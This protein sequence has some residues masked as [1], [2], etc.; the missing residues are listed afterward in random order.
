MMAIPRIAVVLA[1][2]MLFLTACARPSKPAEEAEPPQPIGDPHKISEYLRIVPLDPP[3]DSP[4]PIWATA[5]TMAYNPD[6]EG[7]KEGL[8]KPDESNWYWQFQKSGIFWYKA[9]LWTG[10]DWPIADPVVM[11]LK[12]GSTTCTM[13]SNTEIQSVV[14]D[15]QGVPVER[16]EAKW[17]EDIAED[18]TLAT[19][20]L[21][22]ASGGLWITERMQLTQEGQWEQGTLDVLAHTDMPARFWNGHLGATAEFQGSD[23]STQKMTSRFDADAQQLL[24]EIDNSYASSW[25][26]G[27]AFAVNEVLDPPWGLKGLEGQGE[28]DADEA[29]VWNL[30]PGFAAIGC[31]TMDLL[32]PAFDEDELHPGSAMDWR[33][34]VYGRDGAYLH[35]L[36]IPRAFW[37]HVLTVDPE[38]IPADDG[39]NG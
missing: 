32:P 15:S 23:F 17:H 20:Y 30:L 33:V 29:W 6:N 37:S 4:E 38:Q 22:P 2:L 16:W 25:D 9:P 7:S 3:I 31:P 10:A 24:L 8:R 5:I 11:H 27:L 26:S 14:F 28:V 1:V 36:T 21:V 34:L 13:W 18:K 19:P 12:D 35:H 39:E